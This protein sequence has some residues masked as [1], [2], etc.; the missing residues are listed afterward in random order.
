MSEKRSFFIKFNESLRFVTIMA[1]IDVPLSLFYCYFTHILITCVLSN[2]MLIE[3]A[4]ILVASSLT[5]SN[6]LKR[7]FEG[8]KK[9]EKNDSRIPLKFNIKVP[10][11]IPLMISAILLIIL[12]FLVDLECTSWDYF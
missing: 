9:S 6:K 3:G 2:M 8:T 4:A 12:G 10:N 11:G 7:E 1:I 5:M